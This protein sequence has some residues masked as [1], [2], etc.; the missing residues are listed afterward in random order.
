MAKDSEL[1]DIILDG[2]HVPV[3][4]V[5]EGDV[6]KMVIKSR[7]E[8]NEEDRKKIKKNYKAK[9][10]LVCGIDPDKYKRISTFENTKE[11]WDCLK[12]AHE[13][14]TNAKD[15]TT[16]YET[17]TMKEGE[18]TQEMHTRFTSIT[19]ELNCLREI[20]PL[21]KKVRKILGGFPKSWES[22]LDVITEARNP[23]TLTMDELIGNLNTHE[24]KK[25]PGHEM[26]EVK[27]EKSLALKV[28]KSDFNEEDTDVAYLEKRIVRAMKQSDQF[29]RSGS[30]SKK[31]GTMEV[32]HRC[33]SLEHFIKNCPM[34][35]MDIR[36]IKTLEGDS[37]SESDEGEKTTDISIF[38]V[39]DKKVTFDSLFPFM[40]NTKDEEKMRK[41][42][43]LANILID[44][45]CKMT[46]KKIALEEKVESQKLELIAL[47]LQISETEEQISETK[48]LVTKLKL[49]NLSLINQSEKVNSYECKGKKEVSKFQVVLEEKLEDSQWLLMTALQ[50]N[51]ELEKDLVLLREK[52]KKSLQWTSSS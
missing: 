27:R 41:I 4:K 23:K 2:P 30:S 17:F 19:N 14:T 51:E 34:H 49:K 40:E 42:K 24:L 3:K 22:K 50:K 26:M 44:F 11:I 47:T 15:L 31:G 20:I 9:K 32:C 10:L 21:Y 6:T 52:L 43:M 38:A 48:Q 28:S 33:G 46:E 8:F 39:E 45:I 12:I 5:K 29:Q 18:T 36:I 25:Q 37:S 7:R 13:G 35:K 1:M 16:Q